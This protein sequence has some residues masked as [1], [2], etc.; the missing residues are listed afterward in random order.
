MRKIRFAIA[1]VI[2]LVVSFASLYILIDLLH[3]NRAV[4]YATQTVLALEANF[5]LNDRFTWR[6]RD[7]G[8]AWQ[9]WLRFHSVRFGI[10][11][12]LNQVA[13]F[14]LQPHLG[15]ILANCCCV[16]AATVV[17]WFM[18]DRWVFRARSSKVVVATSEVATSERGPR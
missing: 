17:N 12:P 16:G 7:A 13:F 18:N 1:G 5:I 14:V 15:T 4:A 9:R 10:M 6:D 3:W 2:G 8:T 11:V